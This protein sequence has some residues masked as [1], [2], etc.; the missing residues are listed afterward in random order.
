MPGGDVTDSYDLRT[1]SRRGMLVGAAVAAGSVSVLRQPDPAFA[2]AD[3]GAQDAAGHALLGIGAVL[4][5]FPPLAP[6]GAGLVVGVELANFCKSACEV[7][8]TNSGAPNAGFVGPL[9]APPDGGAP[10]TGVTGFLS[11]AV[12]V[13]QF[14]FTPAPINAGL[15]GVAKEYNSTLVASAK[16]IAYGRALNQALCRRHWARELNLP[17]AAKVQSQ[18][19]SEYFVGLRSGWQDLSVSLQN[20]AA[21]Y[22]AKGPN[23]NVTREQATRTVRGWVMNGFPPTTGALFADARATAY[24]EWSVLGKMALVAS[25]LQPT[26]VHAALKALARAARDITRLIGAIKPHA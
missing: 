15:P 13:Q 4:G 3:A 26:T 10:L 19:A 7:A 2:Y 1:F 24:E 25:Q 14:A 17:Q 11:Q 16:A 9:G 20:L 18:A 23:A 6:A 22:L 21:A 5:L 8:S 12:G